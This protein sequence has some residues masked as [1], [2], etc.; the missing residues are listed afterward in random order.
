GL[1]V[2]TE[3]G[4]SYIRYSNLLRHLETGRHFVRPEKI[5]LYDFALKLYKEGLE[6]M[7][8]KNNILDEAIADMGKDSAV[9]E[10]HDMQ[11]LSMLTCSHVMSPLSRCSNVQGRRK[12]PL[13]AAQVS[14]LWEAPLSRCSNVQGRRKHPL[15]AAQVSRLWEAPLSRC[16]NVQGRRKHPLAAAQVSRLWEAPLSRCSNV[17]GRRKHSLAAA[18]TLGSSSGA[19]SAAQMS[20]FPPLIAQTSI[21]EMSVAHLSDAL[22]PIAQLSPFRCCSNVPC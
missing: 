2:C 3:C 16:S 9:A 17:Q 10:R 11:P 22:V 20:K 14:R 13:A 5:T 6:D 21:A 18:Q 1:F 15:A 8:K 12:H 19:L 4:A 7:I